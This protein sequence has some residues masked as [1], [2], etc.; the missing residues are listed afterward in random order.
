[1]RTEQEI[2]EQVDWCRTREGELTRRWPGMSYEAGVEA[3]LLWVAE[4]NDEPPIESD[5]GDD[6]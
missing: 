6:D 3:A 2:Q 1:M 4:H 5:P